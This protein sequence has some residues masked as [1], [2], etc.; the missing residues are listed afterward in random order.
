MTGETGGNAIMA[1]L[2]AA[3]RSVGRAP[4]RL[5]NRALAFDSHCPSWVLKPSGEAKTGPARNDVSR[6]WLARSSIPLLSGSYGLICT[7]RVTK[8]SAVSLIRQW[9]LKRR[10]IGPRKV[11]N[12]R[13]L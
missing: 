4:A 5:T 6:N 10:S 7:I 13:I 2:S 3:S 9:V 1:A 11:H 8:L 12:G